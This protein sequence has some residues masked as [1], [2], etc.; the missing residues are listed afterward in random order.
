MNDGVLL[1]NFGALQ[2]AGADI[3][4]ALR[5]LRS[6]LDQLERDAAPLVATWAG[7]AQEAYAQRQAR[8][9]AASTDLE[10]I[11]RQIRVAVSESAADYVA[12]ERAATQRFQ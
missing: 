7:D 11:L 5:T 1:V 9:R 8:W 3:D 6:Q 2:Q 10:S 12:T 4:K